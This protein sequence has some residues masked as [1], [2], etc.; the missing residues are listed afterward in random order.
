M[1]TKDISAVRYFKRNNKFYVKVYVTRN[2]QKGALEFGEFDNTKQ[3][4]DFFKQ[5]KASK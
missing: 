4:K 2:N 3:A 5:L 1:T